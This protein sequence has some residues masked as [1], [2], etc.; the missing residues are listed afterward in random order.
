MPGFILFLLTLFFIASFFQ[1]AFF[2]KIAYLFAAI[3]LLARFWT[4]QIQDKLKIKRDFPLHAFPGDQIEV[5]LSIENTSWLPVPGLDFTEVTP[6][7]LVSPPYPPQAFNLSSYAKKEFIYKLNCRRRGY[8]TLGPMELQINDLLGLIKPL[9]LNLGKESF[10]IYP[11]IVPLQRLGLPTRSPLVALP[12]TTPLFEDSSHVIG[13]RSYQPGDSPRRVHWTASASAGS[14]L[15]K[16]FKPT[17]ARETMICLNLHQEDYSLRYR[18]HATELAITTAASITNHVIHQDGLPVGLMTDAFD[19]VQEK[20][21]RFGRPPRSEQSHL[22]SMLEVLARVQPTAEGSFV[23]MLQHLGTQ[24]AWG[25]TLIV[26][27]G[28]KTVELLETL[29]FLRKSGFAIALLVVQMGS[30]REGLPIPKGIK[31]YQIWEEEDLD[32]WAEG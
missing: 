25:S 2:F 8:F 17:V 9:Q 15:V 26:I 3:Y 31:A 19:P 29:I 27:T 14:L 21:I 22:M 13:V 16:Q 23:D 18:Y 7:L 1:V 24:L 10:T 5:R 6:T 12:A 30:L 11:K 4:R 28:K 32:L 20:V